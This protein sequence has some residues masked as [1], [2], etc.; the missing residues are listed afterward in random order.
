MSKLPIKGDY[1]ADWDQIG[2]RVRAETG[3]RCIRCGHP[4]RVGRDD[5]QWSPCDQG[6]N[7]GGPFGARLTVPIHDN[8]HPR[9]ITEFERRQIIDANSNI[10]CGPILAQWRVLTVHHLDGDKSNCRWWNLLAL[11]QRCHLQIQGSVNP[12]IPY[13][14][15]HSEW[16]RPYVAGF[17]AWKYEGKEITRGEAMADISRL[18]SL[19]RLA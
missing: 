13:F 9:F 11:C 1:P 18:L 8:C 14:L 12:E 19:E 5:P 6:C 10:Y 17:Y 16:F 15:E 4:F 3:H 2:D 7:H